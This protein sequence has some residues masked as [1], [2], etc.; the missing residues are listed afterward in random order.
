MNQNRMV[1]FHNVV[2][3]EDVNYIIVKKPPL[4]L[5]P[6]VHFAQWAHMRHFLSTVREFTFQVRSK[7]LTFSLRKLS[8]SSF[9]LNF[10][11]CTTIAG[12]HVVVSYVSHFYVHN[13]VCI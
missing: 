11:E 8:T 12:L 2:L 7:L 9:I 5:S 13:E 4:L 6:P 1:F 3:D 10:S